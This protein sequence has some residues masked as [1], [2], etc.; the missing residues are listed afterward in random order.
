MDKRYRI[1]LGYRMPPGEKDPRRMAG[2]RF[3]EALY[4]R[5]VGT[6]DYQDITGEPYFSPRTDPGGNFMTLDF[7]QDVEYF[8]IPYTE[9]FFRTEPGRRKPVIFQEI[10]AALALPRPV[11]F[12]AVVFPGYEYTGQLERK[13]REVIDPQY[14]DRLLPLTGAK[15]HLYNEEQADA[16]LETIYQ[17]LV[18]RE[19]ILDVIRDA[20]PNVYLTTKAETERVS[21][22]RRLYGVRKLT[23][24]NFAASSLIS[25]IDIS[26]VYGA[27]N[28]FRNWFETGLLEDRI[29]CDI[30][31]A[32]PGSPADRDASLY[33]MR[34]GQLTPGL[35]ELF[36]LSSEAGGAGAR[37]DAERYHFIIRHNFNKICQFK[38]RHRCD[39]L[40][41]YWTDAVLPYGLMKS[42]YPEDERDQNNI[43][44][45]IYG[46]NIKDADRPS[47]HLFENDPATAALYG[48]FS[49][50][51]EAFFTD[52][53]ARA[54]EFSGHPNVDFLF[55]RP[56][57][58]R[59]RLTKDGHGLTAD[60]ITACAKK[61]YPI[62][63]DLLFVDGQI[64]VW[65]DEDCE[66]YGF[67][68]GAMLSALSAQGVNRIRGQNKQILTLQELLEKVT[69]IAAGR[70]RARSSGPIPLLIEIKNDTWDKTPQEERRIR[71]QVISVCRI[72]EGYRGEYA[73]HASDPRI[74]RDVKEYDARI[75]CG[76]ITLDFD[77]TEYRERVPEEYKK[78]HREAR[79]YDYVIPD[80]ISY[81]V[82]DFLQGVHRQRQQDYQLK[83]LGWAVGS[84]GDYYAHR[85]NYDQLLIEYDP[86]AR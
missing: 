46:V 78:M 84:G 27:H 50:S 5:I 41:L 57:I 28:K 15:K 45:D 2:Y 33:K 22:Y 10:E 30:I 73:L 69:R 71:D 76:Q 86:E 55:R 85:K 26:P 39:K 48:I 3:V 31:L 1:F 61:G 74:V 64:L 8:V 67:A 52:G 12:I 56:I 65:R 23:F 81:R 11:R 79:Y 9:G 29:S 40:R 80:F 53:P 18:I 4:E 38:L 43:K 60:E 51:L 54:V 44:V 14:H 70:G 24:L 75:P 36:T 7:L 82:G 32:R 59:A 47:F 13:Y 49:S 34:P 20:P 66:K 62:E 63:V 83:S 21:I 17:E 25:G 37:E 19:S 58:H 35:S 42:E 77:K 16:L 6:A 72:M 68:P